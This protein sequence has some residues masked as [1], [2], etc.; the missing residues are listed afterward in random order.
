[1][2]CTPNAVSRSG[3]D[4]VTAIGTLAGEPRLTEVARSA[5]FATVRRVP[6]P[7]PLNLFLEL[8]G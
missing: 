1:M 2:V 6:S 3:G 7:A 4:E 8:R 5:G